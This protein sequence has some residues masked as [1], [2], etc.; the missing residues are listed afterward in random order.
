MELNFLW[1][2]AGGVFVF[3]FFR[4]ANEW[5]YVGTAYPLPPGDLAW[6]G[7]F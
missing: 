6:D 2:I 1:L 7:L 3:W 5:Y 4:R